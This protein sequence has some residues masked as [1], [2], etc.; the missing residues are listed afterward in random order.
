[1]VDN[2]IEKSQ[3]GNKATTSYIFLEITFN[4]KRQHFQFVLFKLDFV[5]NFINIHP[6]IVV[7]VKMFLLYKK[8]GSKEQQTN[9]YIS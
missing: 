6:S 4:Q 3:G 5:S 7:I 2:L 9:K 1:M 8:G